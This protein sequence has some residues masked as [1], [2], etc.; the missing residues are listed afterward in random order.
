MSLQKSLLQP[1]SQTQSEYGKEEIR[2]PLFTTGDKKRE[3]GKADEY[4]YARRRK[5]VP[6]E[7]NKTWC[8]IV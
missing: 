7:T 4:C 2:S 1:T 3:S 5:I 8:W 6:N